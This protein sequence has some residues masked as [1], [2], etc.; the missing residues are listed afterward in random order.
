MLDPHLRR[1]CTKSKKEG[2]VTG[3][4][5][6]HGLAW[7]KWTITIIVFHK[8]RQSLTVLL[9]SCLEKSRLG[10]TKHDAYFGSQ[11]SLIWTLAYNCMRHPLANCWWNSISTLKMVFVS[12]KMNILKSTILSDVSRNIFHFYQEFENIFAFASFVGG[13][14]VWVFYYNTRHVFL[15]KLPN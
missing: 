11:R 13:V 10:P 12:D 3:I 4:V 14:K 15:S 2:L 8:K 5:N 6:S 9:F 1:R 7:V